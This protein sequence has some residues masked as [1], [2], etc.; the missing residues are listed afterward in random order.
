MGRSRAPAASTARLGVDAPERLAGLALRGDGEVVRAALHGGEDAV[1]EDAHHR[2]AGHDA[3]VS[4]IEASSASV[5]AAQSDR[6]RRRRLSLGVEAAAQQEILVGEDHAG[7]ARP[8][9]RAAMRPAARAYHQ[10]VAVEE[11]L[12]VEVGVGL[13]RE[14]AQ[15]RGAADRR[16]RRAS[17]RSCGAT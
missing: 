3:D 10:E 11:A 9:V 13:A 12:V 16:A 14:A 17:P 1:V 7:A 4:G 8:A 5:A 15:A 2:G 6:V